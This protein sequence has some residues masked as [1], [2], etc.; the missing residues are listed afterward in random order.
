MRRRRPLPPSPIERLQQRHEQI[1][2]RIMA[3]EQLLERHDLDADTYQT[4][5]FRLGLSKLALDACQREIREHEAAALALAGPIEPP[6]PP[7]P[8]EV[9]H[10]HIE[11]MKQQLET[12][13][14]P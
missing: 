14:N 6:G 9:A 3:D 13:R 8:P 1:V 10:Q 2:G 4:I 11:Q 7:A 5:A 12:R